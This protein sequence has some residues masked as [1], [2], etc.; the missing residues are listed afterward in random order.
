MKKYSLRFI[1]RKTEH[2]GGGNHLLRLQLPL[3]AGEFPTMRPGQFVQVAVPGGAVLL[4]RPISIC[5]V[6]PES[7]ELWL[8][9]ARVG[10]GT[11]ILTQQPDGST[12]DLL[13][14]LGN[15]FDLDGVERPL[16]VGGGVGIAPMLYLAQQFAARGIQPRILLGGRTSEHIV[17]REE[18]ERLGHVHY[19]TDDGSLGLQ[20][21][22]TDH[23]VLS[24]S[25][26]DQIYT[27][28]PK[29]MMLAVAR[30]AEA[31]SIRCYLSLENSMACGIGACL[32]CVEDLEGQGNTCVCTEGP[33]FDSRLIKKL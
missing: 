10:K 25:D 3:S 4:R 19:T 23:P 9:I 12:L 28:G 24:E 29:V 16:L 5:S 26:V 8:L 33:I 15:S 18:F 21:R 14:P 20:G 27:C 30:I 22:V 31:R 2:L 13:I 1:L 6:Q 11:S 7:R 32:C 17:L